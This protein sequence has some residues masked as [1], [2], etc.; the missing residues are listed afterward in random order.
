M[1]KNK[2]NIRKIL[3]NNL[4]K[5]YEDKIVKIDIQDIMEYPIK[6]NKYI[7]TYNLELREKLPIVRAKIVVDTEKKELESYEPG[8][9]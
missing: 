7:V 6:D 4:K 5:L 1:D 2:G 8:L 9:P 3:E